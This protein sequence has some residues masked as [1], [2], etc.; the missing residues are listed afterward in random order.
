M[1]NVISYVTY[2]TTTFTT[3]TTTTTMLPRFSTSCTQAVTM[4]G[5]V[6]LSRLAQ[7]EILTPNTAVLWWDGVLLIVL[8]AAVYRTDNTSAY[9]TDGR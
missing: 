2:S 9:C 3:T 7:V 4:V 5:T 8:S 6:L 1:A